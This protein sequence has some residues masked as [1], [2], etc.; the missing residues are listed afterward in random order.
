MMCMTDEDFNFSCCE[1]KNMDGFTGS[2]DAGD[3][4]H[5]LHLRMLQLTIDDKEKFYCN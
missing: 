2:V 3:N 4:L 1:S 5:D